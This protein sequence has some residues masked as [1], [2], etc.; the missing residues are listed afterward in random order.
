MEITDRIN[1]V[2]NL[3]QISADV[4]KKAITSLQVGM[5]EVD[6]AN[7]VKLEFRKRGIEEFWYDIPQ[8]VL[9]GV[10]RFKEGTTTA[11]YEIKKPSKDIFLKE[12]LPVFIDLS[13]VDPQTKQWGDWSSTVVF[14]P[15]RVRDN[16]QP[17]FL[18][19]LRQ[20]HRQGITLITSKITGSEVID[21]YLEEFKKRGI[22][23]LDVR[24]N[25]G[26]SIHA[27]SKNQAQRVWLDNNN[28]NSLR[29]GI[30][31]IEVGGFRIGKKDKRRTVVGRFEECVYIPREG[32]AIMLGSNEL[33]PLKV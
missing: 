28:K 23:L 4:F 26:H 13:P 30:Y 15:K 17:I 31:A 11:D 21:Y 25:V 27:G 18:E 22:T 10:E 14:H 9:I 6:I 20:I 8:N 29:V 7:L 19:E 2:S 3:Q 32:S 1:I 16:E 12:D 33:V 5:S 24:N